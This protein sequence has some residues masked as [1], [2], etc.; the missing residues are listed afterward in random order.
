[1]TPCSV[2][3]SATIPSSGWN[4][5]S[6]P[7]QI[8]SFH[9]SISRVRSSHLM[10]S[11]ETTEIFWKSNYY[12]HKQ[13]ILFV[14]RCVGEKVMAARRTSFSSVFLTACAVEIMLICWSLDRL[15]SNR[16]ISIDWLIHGV[17]ETGADCLLSA[18]CAMHFT[19]MLCFYSWAD[20]VASFFQAFRHFTGSNISVCLSVYPSA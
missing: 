15:C 6:N 19:S 8:R 3:W 18:V 9:L 2:R 4:F 12:R 5:A 20:K 1:M 11:F 16:S 13:P 14:C 7:F 17:R 10:M